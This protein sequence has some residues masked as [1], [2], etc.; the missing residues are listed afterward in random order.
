MESFPQTII[1]VVYW[2]LN[3]NNTKESEKWILLSSFAA[4]ALNLFLNLLNLLS[5]ARTSGFSWKRYFSLTINFKGA[6]HLPLLWRQRLNERILIIDRSIIN[7]EKVQRMY[8]WNQIAR[9]RCVVLCN[10]EDVRK[11]T[12][13]LKQ[14]RAKSAALIAVDAADFML[15]VR[16]ICWTSVQ[17]I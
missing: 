11:Y 4:S 9:R 7:M 3:A 16:A 5:A 2:Q 1:Q 8:L 12:A 15:E 6:T 14:Q 17:A 10:E 13:V